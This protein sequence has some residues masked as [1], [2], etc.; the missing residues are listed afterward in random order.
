MRKYSQSEL[1]KI[2][3]KYFARLPDDGLDVW[4]VDGELVRERHIDFIAGGTHA[5]WKFIPTNDI[6][7]EA[8]LSPREQRA[9]L[10]HEAAERAKMLRGM[11]YA[12][13]HVI[14]NRAERAWRTRHRRV[15]RYT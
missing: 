15:S 3:V 1:N 14:A 12:K 5:R 8:N 7:I 11:P 9:T 6:W 4:I 13:A 2:R 10:V